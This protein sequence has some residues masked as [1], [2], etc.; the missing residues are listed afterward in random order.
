MLRGE[1]NLGD[2]VHWLEQVLPKTGAAEKR[3]MTNKAQQTRGEEA[4]RP[5]SVRS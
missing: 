1:R 3:G 5:I 2:I 4:T